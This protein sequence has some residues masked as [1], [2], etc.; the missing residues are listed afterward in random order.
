MFKEII[1]GAAATIGIGGEP[2]IERNTASDFE[3]SSGVIL[4]GTNIIAGQVGIALPQ[5]YHVALDAVS[6]F[7]RD[8]SC[9]NAKELVA[10]MQDSSIS[11]ADAIDKYDVGA[12]AFPTN[13]E[14]ATFSG[15]HEHLSQ[16]FAA[17]LTELQEASPGCDLSGSVQSF[18]T[19]DLIVGS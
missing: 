6:E 15:Y 19:Q 2:D 11:I 13:I 7:G 9:A 5:E 17:S 4:S 1:L 16:S 14:D 18:E 10:A 12:Q 8:T 3:Y